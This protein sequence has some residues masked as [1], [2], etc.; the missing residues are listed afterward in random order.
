[1]TRKTQQNA[2]SAPMFKEGD[3][4][5]VTTAAT[6]NEPLPGTITGITKT[7]WFV[8]LL[9]TPLDH[10]SCKDGKVSARSGSLQWAAQ[11]QMLSSPTP[12]P[13]P[14]AAPTPADPAAGPDDTP[15]THP[16]AYAVCPVC[17]S[18]HLYNGR[19]N[20]K[21]IVVDD[22]RIVGCHDCDWEVEIVKA[23]SGMAQ[24]LANARPRYM[25]THRP[26]GTPS[27]DCADAIARELRE[28]EPADVATLADRICGLAHGTC[29]QKYG[30]LNNGQIRMNSGN[31]IRAY[32]KRINEEG[33]EAEINRVAGLLGLNFDNESD[34]DE[35]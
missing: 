6:N 34:E 30:H 14:E 16:L 11:T 32:W 10:P 28:Y 26:D 17:G 29:I 15:A 23:K 12:A 31:R 24:T 1:M 7:G 18:S 21:G 4:V 13:A 8:I 3:R 35:E 22:D 5:T 33:N 20:D 19:V 2:A 9:D 25:K 27:A